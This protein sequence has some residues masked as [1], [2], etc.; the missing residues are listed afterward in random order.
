M[1]TDLARTNDIWLQNQVCHFLG[2]PDGDDAGILALIECTPHK[3]P[4][5]TFAYVAQAC[6]PRREA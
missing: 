6:R 3:T 2:G 5:A 1:I 4:H